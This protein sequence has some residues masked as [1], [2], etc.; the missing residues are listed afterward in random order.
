MNSGTIRSGKFLIVTTLAPPAFGGTPT[1]LGK[2]LRSFPEDS[3]C[4][5]ADPITLKIPPVSDFHNCHYHFFD[6]STLDLRQE[7]G[8]KVPNYSSYTSSVSKHGSSVA[9]T[10]VKRILRNA[11]DI[12]YV[13][14]TVRSAYRSGL[15]I[16]AME[17]ISSIVAISDNGPAFLVSYLLSRKTK[18]PYSVF[19]FDIYK[20]NFF[21]PLRILVSFFMEKEIIRRASVVFVAGEGLKKHYENLYRKECILIPNSCDIPETMSEARPAKNP[22]MISYTGAYYWAQ[23]ES[24]E[25]FNKTVANNPSVNFKIFS[26]D[27]SAYAGVSQKDSVAIQK[28]SDILL[29]PLSFTE[30]AFTEVIKTAPTG[31]LAEYLVSG[32]P[33]LVHAP[34]DSWVSNYIR[35][36]QAGIVVDEASP[37]A[38]LNGIEKIKN[39]DTRGTIVRNAYNLAKKNHDVKING[40]KFYNELSKIF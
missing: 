21:S 34:S 37:K 16:M 18:N 23:Q 2:Y 40:Q 15:K 33:I 4:F 6:G 19:L 20:G 22:A 32:V 35:I 29:L 17:K 25:R 27:T 8:I 1:I 39:Y 26:H 31:K 9:L 7:S 30:N 38:I 13:I 28:D 36:Y 14:K 10:F 24:I 12:L 11:L 5:L 3:Y